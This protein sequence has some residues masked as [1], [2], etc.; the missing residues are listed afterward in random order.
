MALPLYISAAGV[1]AA[2][3]GTLFVRTHEKATQ[4][5]LLKV[6]SAVPQHR[7]HAGSFTN[8]L[9]ILLS[10]MLSGLYPHGSASEVRQSAVDMA[11]A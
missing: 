11:Y 1:L 5:D 2:I 4:S 8:G 6:Q 10:C 7:A 3:V 9:Q